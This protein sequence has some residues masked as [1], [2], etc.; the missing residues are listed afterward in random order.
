MM[1]DIIFSFEPFSLG[2]SVT[3]TSPWSWWMLDISLIREF[4]VLITAVYLTMLHLLWRSCKF[5]TFS[6][7]YASPKSLFLFSFHFCSF[8]N[9]HWEVFAHVFFFCLCQLIP[10]CN[11]CRKKQECRRKITDRRMLLSQTKICL[12]FVFMFCFSKHVLI[13]VIVTFAQ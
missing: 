11:R 13:C 1:W 8:P 10:N 9:M 7:F 5:Q 2:Y 12:R 6:Y 3:I 4:S